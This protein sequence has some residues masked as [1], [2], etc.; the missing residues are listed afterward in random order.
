[1]AVVASSLSASDLT[2]AARAANLGATLDDESTHDAPQLPPQPVKSDEC[3]T[4]AQ[5]Y[6]AVCEDGE[7]SGTWVP[8]PIALL[9]RATY[10]LDLTSISGSLPP[11]GVIQGLRLPLLACLT[12]FPVFCDVSPVPRLG[13]YGKGKEKTLFGGF[14]GCPHHTIPTNIKLAMPSVPSSEGS[15]DAT[16]LMFPQWCS[17][18]PTLV[19]SIYRLIDLFHARTDMSDG[20]ILR[21]TKLLQQFVS[22][23]TAEQLQPYLLDHVILGAAFA[24]LQAYC[25]TGNDD[26]LRDLYTKFTEGA[27]LFVD[28]H[29]LTC[30]QVGHSKGQCPR[31]AGVWCLQLARMHFRSLLGVAACMHLP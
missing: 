26:L 18:L 20:E 19:A 25:A 27:K 28:K 13:S 3:V 24:Q 22:K 4:V 11:L 9:L 14:L 15:A 30:N 2:A 31:C 7:V 12:A 1:M 21:V 6:T 8:S 10:V 17:N 29:C 5:A 16:R 23:I